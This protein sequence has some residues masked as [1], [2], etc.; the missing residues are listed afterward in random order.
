MALGVPVIAADIE[1]IREV[2]G[3]EQAC[4]W[5]DPLDPHDIAKK[6]SSVL[7]GEVDLRGLAAPGR[8]IA[9]RYSITGTQAAY[10]KL[11]RDLLR[12]C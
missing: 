12:A 9:D 11:Y 3:K 1:G 4:V 10:H 2:V 5:I 7:D 8:L 6:I